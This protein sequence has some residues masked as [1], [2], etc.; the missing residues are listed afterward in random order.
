MSVIRGGFGEPY[1]SEECY[2]QGGRYAAAVMLRNQTG[3]CGI[4]QT[5]VQAH[6]YP[7]DAHV[8]GIGIAGR[9]DRV[10][11]RS[12]CAAVVPYEGMTL[13]VCG[14][15]RCIARAQQHLQGHPKC[16]MCQR[17]LV[18]SLGRVDHKYSEVLRWIACLREA[19]GCAARILD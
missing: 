16:C 7:W 13:F 12:D 10:A 5:P 6:M 19:C 9:N 18:A 14:D 1:C 15:R 8:V 4:C 17:A 11:G 2:K 3:V